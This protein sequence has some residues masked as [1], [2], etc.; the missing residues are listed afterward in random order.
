MVDSTSDH[1]LLSFMNAFSGYHQIGLLEADK[2]KTTFVTD[3]GV[4]NYK[5]MPFG[6]RNDGATYQKL[7]DKVF[8]DKRGR[9]I[10]A[11][12]DDS[13]VKSKTDRKHLDDLTETFTTAKSIIND[14]ILQPHANL[15]VK[16]FILRPDSNFG[17]N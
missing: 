10:E 13:I 6:L 5:G 4:Y 7:V 12:V 9:N 2:Q 16:K 3:Y 8:A 14:Q 11:S 1:A 17:R 15:V